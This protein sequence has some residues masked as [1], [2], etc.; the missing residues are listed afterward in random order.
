MTILMLDAKSKARLTALFDRLDALA[1]DAR[2]EDQ[3]QAI[4]NLETG[5]LDAAFVDPAHQGRGIARRLLARLQGA[6]LQPTSEN[7]G[8]RIRRG[9]SL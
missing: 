8:F 1:A 3:K 9:G 2:A 6:P 7:L 4:L 5:E